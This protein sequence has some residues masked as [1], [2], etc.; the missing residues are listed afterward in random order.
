MDVSRNPVMPD[1][2]RPRRESDVHSPVKRYLHIIQP[3]SFQEELHMKSTKVLALLVAAV[4]VFAGAAFAQ[5]APKADEPKPVVDVS[6]VLFLD[7]G[8]VQK[9]NENS[10][11]KEGSDTMRLQRAY[12]NFAKK[13]DDMW[14][15][16]VTLDGVGVTIK[17]TTVDDDGGNVD[18]IID[19]D[20]VSTS[21]KANNVMFIKN[22]YVQMK[23]DFDPITLTVQYGV[24]GTPIIGAGDGMSGARWIYNTY[25]DKSADLLG[26]AVDVSSADL[27]LKADISVMKMVTLTGMYANGSGYKFTEDQQVA[28]KAYWGVLSITPIK[29]LAIN[30]YYHTRDVAPGSDDNTVTYYGGGIGWSDKSFKVGGNFILGERDAASSEPEN[31]KDYM[32]YE[33]FANINLADV[34]GVPVLVYGKYAYGESE[35]DDDVKIEGTQIWAGLGY[36]FNKS[37]Q[38]MALYQTGEIEED[39]AGTKEKIEE[40]MIW[41]KTEV[42]F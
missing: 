9:A 3:K 26:D 39:A 33:V 18:G 35:A 1:L 23:K 4:F 21:T 25:L 12:L 22:A 19:E 29:E 11:L 7:W 13:I 40:D 30:G 28:D 34:A 41:L 5:D 15:V 32:L 27:G 42:K 24:V 37:V 2:A 16:K 38:V 36:Q 31:K 20:E 6:G 10:S 17:E 14:S 8:Y